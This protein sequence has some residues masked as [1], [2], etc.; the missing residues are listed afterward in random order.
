MPARIQLRAKV[1]ALVGV[2]CV[3]LGDH[4]GARA[5][6]DHGIPI[7]FTSMTNIYDGQLAMSGRVLHH[8]GLM[9]QAEE[10]QAA[11]VIE[12]RCAWCDRENGVVMNRS[13]LV[14]HGICQRHLAGM[15]STLEALRRVEAEKARIAA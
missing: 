9:L 5:S 3:D 7:F 4:R 13:A 8:I 14:S 15:A 6:G 12:V 2:G 11:P 10:A 1:R